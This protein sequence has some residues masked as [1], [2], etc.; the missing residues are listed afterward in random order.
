MQANTV[1]SVA[2]S[3]S[4]RDSS[5]SKVKVDSSNVDRRSKPIAEDHGKNKLKGIQTPYYPDRRKCLSLR[6]ATKGVTANHLLDE[7]N[8]DQMQDKRCH[9]PIGHYTYSLFGH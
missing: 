1:K 4:L 2:T 5:H 6:T 8:D 7:H 9:N 3:H